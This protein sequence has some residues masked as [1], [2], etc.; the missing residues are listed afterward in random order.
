MISHGKLVVLVVPINAVRVGHSGLRAADVTNRIDRGT[1]EC[2]MGIDDG[3]GGRDVSAQRLYRVAVC[4]LG[5]SFQSYR[6]IVDAYSFARRSCYHAGR[7]IL[8]GDWTFFLR[9]D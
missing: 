2:G 3:T 5:E 7:I 4:L 9:D 8:V 6:D 1:D